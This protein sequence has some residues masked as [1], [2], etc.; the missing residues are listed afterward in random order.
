MK[1]TLREKKLKSGNRSLYL[2][3][4]PPIVVDSKSTR[5]E[6]LSL[7]IHEKP[8][9]ELERNH[10]KETRLLAESI[11]SRR[12]LDLQA[13]PHGFISS[14]KRKG[15]FLAFFRQVVE[16]R[17]QDSV[18]AF[19][20]WRS[21]FLYL[22]EF[23]GGYCT[24]QQVDRNFVERF[25]SYLLTCEPLKIK[26]SRLREK[27]RSKSKKQ[28]LG[29]NTAKSYFERFRSAVREAHRNN[30]LNHDPTL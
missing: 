29:A 6:F 7:Y 24:F 27:S 13:N 5:R 15:D 2:D 11:R 4:Y 16:R 12:Q 23:C 1:V 18:S 3:F 19:E 8:K 25:R 10:N 22:S 20:C 26:E 14:R 21:I 9:T 28:T 30:Y 17:R